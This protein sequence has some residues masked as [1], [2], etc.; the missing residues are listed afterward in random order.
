MKAA[1]AFE[2]LISLEGG[3]EDLLA[4]ARECLRRNPSPPEH[5]AVALGL[6]D[7]DRALE[8]Y[9]GG[10][11]AAEQIQEWAD[12][13]DASEHV[14]YQSGMEAAIGE[15]LFRLSTPE[16]NEAISHAVAHDL[17][18]VLETARSSRPAT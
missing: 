8:L 11:L 10:V 2:R 4:D 7:L 9:V 5:A 16:I 12:L 17:R 18:V 13:L 14:E 1:G 6:A 3:I 15:V